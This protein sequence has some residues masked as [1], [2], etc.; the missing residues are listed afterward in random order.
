MARQK[1]EDNFF[2]VI[3]RR[4]PTWATVATVIA[5]YPVLRYLL[6]ALTHGSLWA[7]IGSVFAPW[8]TVALMLIALYAEADKYKRRQ[9]LKQQSSLGTLQSITWQEFE[10]LVGEAYRRQGYN[11]E[12]TGG[13]GPDGG[14]DL[15]LRRGG[16]TALV[17]CK[18]WKTQSVGVKP[19]R[20]LRGVAANEKAT[21]GIFVTCGGY[22]QAALCEA[23]GQPPLELIDGPKLLKLVQEVQANLAQPPQTLPVQVAVPPVDAA[24]PMNAAQPINEAAEPACP[25]CGS[26]M[27]RKTARQGPNTGRDFWGC[28]RFPDCRGTRP[29]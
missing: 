10:M 3:F 18:Q 23:G 15:I 5:S 29:A 14:V 9:L 28:S 21:R 17:Q 8:L 7:L 27:R 2:Y 22:T 11:V 4:I 19:L 12:E 1:V 20:E 25:N 24:Q 6:P 16:E 13:R 26:A